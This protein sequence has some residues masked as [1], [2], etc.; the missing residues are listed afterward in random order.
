MVRIVGYHSN[1]T[2]EFC[3][4]LCVNDV[5]NLFAVLHIERAIP[6]SG[7]E[8]VERWPIRILTF[9][10]DKIDKISSDVVG[11]DFLAEN[12]FV[13]ELYQVLN[14]RVGLMLSCILK[15]DLPKFFIHASVEIPDEK[16]RPELIK[17]VHIM[18]TD[19]N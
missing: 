14:P 1:S 10:L 3:F 8:F 17:N 11:N 4:K 13:V 9:A 12:R 7:S 15:S 16:M 18:M 6:P 2:F 5:I 19:A